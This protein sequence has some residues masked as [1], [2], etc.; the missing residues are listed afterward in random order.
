M[1]RM[2]APIVAAMLLLGGPALAQTAAPAAGGTAAAP[3]RTPRPASAAQQA[4]REKMRS[5]AADA[6]TQTLRGDERRAFMRN[7][8]RRAPAASN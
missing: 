8:L 5:C 7:C 6:R 1:G 4:Q 3:A 2:L